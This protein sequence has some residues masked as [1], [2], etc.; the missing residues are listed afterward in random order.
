MITHFKINY[1]FLNYFPYQLNS[2]LKLKIN[3]K[4]NYFLFYFIILILN[5]YRM[6]QNFLKIIHHL[7]LFLHYYYK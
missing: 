2:H 3:S 1:L 4:F 6:F 7:S 5:F